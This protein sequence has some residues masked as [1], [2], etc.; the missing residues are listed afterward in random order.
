MTAS[1]IRAT[2]SLLASTILIC[3]LIYLNSRAADPAGFSQGAGYGQTLDWIALYTGVAMAAVMLA[4]VL[5]IFRNTSFNSAIFV[6][7]ALVF[8]GSLYLVADREAKDGEAWMAA[9]PL[10]PSLALVASARADTQGDR[11]HPSPVLSTQAAGAGLWRSDAGV[12]ER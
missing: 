5:G 12:G 7:S 11:M 10:H 3:G 6:V 4:F 2:A 8:C 1:C 9:M